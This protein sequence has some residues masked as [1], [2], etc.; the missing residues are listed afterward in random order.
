MA[1]S[2][3]KKNGKAKK[4]PGGGMVAWVLAPV[5]GFV[6]LPTFI[7]LLIGMAPTLVAFFIMDRHPSK[8]TTRAV[9]YL[10]FSGCLP[11]AIDL[12][13]G[14][15]VWEFETLVSIISDP[16]NLLVMYSSA[17]VGWMILFATPPV[18]AAYLAVTSDMRETTLKARQK[19]LIENWGR[20]V[21]LGAM[22]AELSDDDDD[23]DNESGQESEPAAQL[24]PPS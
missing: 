2:A 11:Y 20:N 23:E 14:G 7:L 15:G 19:E 13:R 6:A 18:V 17:A 16:F 1:K 21:R 4:A 9:G 5:V 22:G 10:N 24:A 12:W 3:S 8:Y